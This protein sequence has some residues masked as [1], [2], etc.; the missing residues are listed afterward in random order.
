MNEFETRKRE[1]LQPVLVEAGAALLDCQSFEYA[2]SYLLFLFARLGTEGMPVERAE[3]ILND[4]EKKTAGQLVALLKQH[5]TVSP[6]IER[7]LTSALKARNHLVHRYLI[8]SIERMVNPLEHEKLVSEIRALR[9]QVRRSSKQ[10]D[11]FVK[12]LAEHLDGIS[13]AELEAEI[14]AKFLADTKRH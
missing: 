2:I 14:K 8:E 10:L 6:T 11:P 1:V 9:T 4:E 13:L 7:E 12:Y 5:V 3:S